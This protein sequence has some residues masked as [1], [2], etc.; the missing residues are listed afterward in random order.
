MSGWIFLTV[1]CLAFGQLT[2]SWPAQDQHFRLRTALGRAEAIDESWRNFRQ[3]LKSF[4][5][6]NEVNDDLNFIHDFKRRGPNNDYEKE[7]FELTN[8]ARQQGRYCG[9]TWYPATT[10]LKWNDELGDA[11]RGHAENMI[12]NDY[13]S[14]TD[15]DGSNFVDRE[16]AA[17]YPRNCAAAE[18]IASN[19]TPQAT[20]DAFIE[21]PGHC[22]NIMNK[23]SKAIGIGYAEGGPDGGY[24][25][26]DFGR[27]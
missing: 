3:K 27:C 17:G 23:N 9:S 21:S 2:H 6:N 26:Q 15:I 18:N 20:V 13:F 11:A 1:I 19:E 8:K 16:E 10:E 14:H 25:V 7:V 5:N 24:W 12:D 22:V 4:R